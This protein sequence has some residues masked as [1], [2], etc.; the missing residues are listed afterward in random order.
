M[1]FEQLIF[2]AQRRANTIPDYAKLNKA[3][4]PKP[5]T[6]MVQFKDPDGL[7]YAVQVDAPGD[8]KSVT[9]TIDFTDVPVLSVKYDR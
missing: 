3:E 4:P 2:E 6:H 9:V 8:A 1:T 7:K 5:V